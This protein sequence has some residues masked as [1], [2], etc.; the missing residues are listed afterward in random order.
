MHYIR[1]QFVFF[2][3]ACRGVPGASFAP[4]GLTSSSPNSSH[5][6]QSK[7]Y[8]AYSSSAADPTLSFTAD[9]DDET[10]SGK[11]N[12]SGSSDAFGNLSVTELKRLLIDRG[13]DFRDCL[14]KRDLVER[15]RESE[16]NG[17]NSFRQWQSSPSSEGL[18]NEEV[19]LINT[20]KRVSPSVANIKT[21]AVVQAQ[22]GLRLRPMEVPLG[23]GSGFL[24]DEE[25]HVVTV[26]VMDVCSLVDV[27]TFS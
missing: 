7:K 26:S 4:F 10:F 27:T 2:A 25:G 20:F 8:A 22:D 24:W 18:M 9:T 13:I 16:V 11:K 23:T 12:K 5:D 14:E 3:L 21:T 1:K 19:A 6:S 17:W 15:L